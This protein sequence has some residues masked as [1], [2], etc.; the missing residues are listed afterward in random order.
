[1]TG[2]L[3]LAAWVALMVPAAWRHVHPLV[4]AIML[5]V[6]GILA[7]AVFLTGSGAAYAEPASP[8]TPGVTCAGQPVLLD[9][10]VSIQDPLGTL[11]FQA[12]LQ[13]MCGQ[14]PPK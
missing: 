9:P 8:V 10:R 13:A 5:A 2:W 6:I 3:I 4:V 7:T 11:V 12:M 1:M 14:P